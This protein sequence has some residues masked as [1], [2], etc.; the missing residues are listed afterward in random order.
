MNTER[1]HEDGCAS[2]KSQQRP[3]TTSGYDDSKCGSFTTSSH[4]SRFVLIRM[5]N[6]AV[7]SVA[8]T[9]WP[10]HVAL[11]AASQRST[12]W[13]S[14]TKNVECWFRN[15]D[16]DHRCHISC[17][18]MMRFR[19]QPCYFMVASGT[20]ERRRTVKAAEEIM[21]L[22]WVTGNCRVRY[23]KS[24]PC[25]ELPSHNACDLHAESALFESGPGHQLVLTEFLFV[26]FSFPP[27]KCRNHTES[28]PR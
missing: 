6:V 8:L 13:S 21:T 1:S 19:I 20:R 24:W 22:E 17:Y 10:M 7:S 2:R 9:I 18:E 5:Y 4:G 14:T 3:Y 25:M 11:L 26:D 16:S 27:E 12:T 28:R 15:R 23:S